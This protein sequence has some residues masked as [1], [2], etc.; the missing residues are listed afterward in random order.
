MY[1][2]ECIPN[3]THQDKINSICKPSKPEMFFHQQ[4][5]SASLYQHTPPKPATTIGFGP[6]WHTAATTNIFPAS[7]IDQRLQHR[8]Q[9]S[10][11]GSQVIADNTNDDTPPVTKW[12]WPLQIYSPCTQPDPQGWHPAWNFNDEI[13]LNLTSFI[14]KSHPILPHF[15]H[16]DT[17]KSLL[18]ILFPSVGEL[19]HEKSCQ[20]LIIMSWEPGAAIPN[21]TLLP[22]SNPAYKALQCI[23]M[24]DGGLITLEHTL[25]KISLHLGGKV[26]D[27]QKQIY[28]MRVIFSEDQT[29]F[30]NRAGILH[31]NMIS[32]IQDVSP[33]LL[34]ETFFTQIMACQGFP[35]FL[36]TK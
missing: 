6:H 15:Y 33:N 22:V 14:N 34:F 21:A 12:L 11:T 31:K 2:I 5:H 29:S 28:D 27:L 8:F 4:H 10:V 35:P 17:S 20:N 3:Q 9:P 7:H 30:I 25:H 32:S 26:E 36:R 24:K 13:T 1:L 23:I 16:I 18:H 19:L